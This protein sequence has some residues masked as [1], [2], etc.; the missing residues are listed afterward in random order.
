MKKVLI[1]IGVVGIVGTVGYFVLRNP[2]FRLVS[3]KLN[4]DKDSKTFT[5]KLGRQ[6]HSVT[7]NK[8]SVIEQEFKFPLFVF[9]LTANSENKLDSDGFPTVTIVETNKITKST[10]SYNFDKIQKS[11]NTI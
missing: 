8:N 3:M 7:V 9:S 5:F 11:N 2:E 6:L 1:T 4:E 10:I